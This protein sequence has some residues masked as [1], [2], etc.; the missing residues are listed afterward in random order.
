MSKN[1]RPQ[2]QKPRNPVAYLMQTRDGRR[3]F[4]EKTERAGRGRGSY[5]RKIK[6]RNQEED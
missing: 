6:H 3:L 2:K 1:R 5:T 4:G